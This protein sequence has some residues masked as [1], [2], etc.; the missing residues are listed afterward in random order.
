MKNEYKIMTDAEFDSVNAYLERQG[1]EKERGFGR[2]PPEPPQLGYA[3]IDIATKIIVMSPLSEQLMEYRKGL[4]N[5][6]FISKPKLLI[7]GNPTRF[8]D[9][10][11]SAFY[12]LE[13]L[14]EQDSKV[15][16]VML[17]LAAQLNGL[18]AN[19]AHLYQVIIEGDSKEF[20][21][22]HGANF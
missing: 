16:E 11:D 8:K 18:R 9:E 12:T 22:I 13:Q 19:S 15:R 17:G 4:E 6:A 3:R 7:V 2:R 1:F 5:D 20:E 14:S 21:T 10:K